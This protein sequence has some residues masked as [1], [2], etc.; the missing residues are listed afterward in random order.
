MVN[1]SFFINLSACFASASFT[2]DPQ[3]LFSCSFGTYFI[4][5]GLVTL[6]KCLE[7]IL[8]Y[9]FSE[10]PLSKC[11][12]DISRSSR[13]FRPILNSYHKK[14]PIYFFLFLILTA[15]KKEK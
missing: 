15:F 7:Q 8:S 10:S 5:Q 4:F 1:I 2:D 11:L 6:I 9:T 12:D 13:I 14:A 3:L